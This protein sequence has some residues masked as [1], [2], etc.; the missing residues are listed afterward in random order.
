LKLGVDGIQLVRSFARHEVIGGW[1][2]GARLPRP[3]EL[4]TEMGSVFLFRVEGHS[5]EELM[6]TL[7]ELERRGVGQQRER[8]FG[9][10]QICSPFHLEVKG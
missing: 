4:A 5:Q 10:V 7:R 3:T 9:Q 8:G 6:D 1:H 2:W